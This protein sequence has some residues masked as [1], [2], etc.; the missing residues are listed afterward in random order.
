[1]KKRLTILFALLLCVALVCTFVACGDKE[2]KPDDGGKTPV[3][4]SKARIEQSQVDS[5]VAD[6]KVAAE[7]YMSYN[8]LG[9]GE[10]KDLSFG[11][12]SELSAHTSATISAKYTKANGKESKKPIAGKITVTTTDNENYAVSIKWTDETGAEFKGEFTVKAVHVN[13]GDWAGSDKSANLGKVDQAKFEGVLSSIVNSVLDIVN[14]AYQNG[15]AFISDDNGTMGVS[16]TGYV[17]VAGHGYE[18]AINGQAGKTSADTAISV[19]ARTADADAPALG[20]YYDNEKLYVNFNGATTVQKYVDGLAIPELVGALTA[21]AIANVEA[22]SDVLVAPIENGKFFNWLGEK[23]PSASGMMGMV[24]SL[25]PNFFNVAE[26]AVV[27][28]TQYQIELNLGSLIGSLQDILTALGIDL[29]ATIQQFAPVILEYVNYVDYLAYVG[30]DAGTIAGIKEFFGGISTMSLAELQGIEGS[31]LIT[32]VVGDAGNAEGIEISLNM[33]A[34]EFKWSAS[35]KAYAYGPVNFAV[36]LK[37]LFVGEEFDAVI[38]DVSKYEEIKPLNVQITGDVDTFDVGVETVYTYNLYTDIDFG[39]IFDAVIAYVGGDENALAIVDASV[40]LHIV[41]GD[42]DVCLVRYDFGDTFVKAVVGEETYRFDV[43]QF[44]ADYMAMQNAEPV[45]EAGEDEEVSIID[46]IMAVVEIV[47]GAIVVGENGDTVVD[48]NADTVNE[49]LAVFG[50]SNDI[51]FEALVEVL[52]SACTAEAGASWDWNDVHYEVGADASWDVA[53]DG[54]VGDV[55][56]T[57]VVTG[58]ENTLANVGV[59]AGWDF[60]GANKTFDGSITVEDLFNA[61]VEGNW[62]TAEGVGAIDVEVVV[63]E[64]TYSVVVDGDLSDWETNGYFEGT[65]VY[66]DGTN[67][68]NAVVTLDTSA[69]ATTGTVFTVTVA[70]PDV[71]ETTVEVTVSQVVVD[72]EMVGVKVVIVEDVV[73][74]FADVLGEYAAVLGLKTD[75]ANTITLTATAYDCKATAT[76]QL[77]DGDVYGT[78]AYYA[79]V[80]GKL[81]EVGVYGY[82]NFEDDKTGFGVHVPEFNWGGS[83]ADAAHEIEINEDTVV[84]ITLESI[85]EFIMNYGTE[86]EPVA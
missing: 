10:S 29:D 68:F 23:M 48:L 12:K 74:T 24:G 57:V 75:A 42:T 41:T 21:E 25:L 35:G 20:L 38:P 86:A 81:D 52:I 47:Q 63:G 82:V 77:N 1:M 61:V 69:W 9:E 85:M 83:Y 26:D 79:M 3:D 62:D 40:V 22:S 5:A 2:E 18:L 13:Y 43:A 66:T 76:F 80:D 50:L 16:V 56:A 51:N 14:R 7:N 8:K 27:G 73:K 84:D 39:S 15:T 55:G 71:F 46:Q 45:V 72:G 44:I 78:V 4:T 17:E 59:D 34:N 64:T 65:G 53:E 36:G 31:L 33:P 28:G 19:E 49:V 67:T 58:G 32:A 54:T 70:Q 11:L 60:S 30:V 6:L 37:D